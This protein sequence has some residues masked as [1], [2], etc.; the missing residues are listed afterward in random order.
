LAENATPYDLFRNLRLTCPNNFQ[1]NTKAIPDLLWQSVNVF[2]LLPNFVG[3][4][5]VGPCE[6]LP[7]F[8]DAESV[9][10]FIYVAVT[11]PNPIDMPVNYQKLKTIRDKAIEK[12]T[13]PNAASDVINNPVLDVGIYLLGDK[14]DS[15]PPAD[16]LLDALTKIEDLLPKDL[17]DAYSTYVLYVTTQ[18]KKELTKQAREE[19]RRF[20][21]KE[22][23]P[24]FATFEPL[25]QEA[26]DY[27]RSIVK[28]KP[29]APEFPSVSPEVVWKSL[30]PKLASADIT[31]IDVSKVDVHTIDCTDIYNTAYSYASKA[32]PNAR[33]LVMYNRT[34]SLLADALYSLIVSKSTTAVTPKEKVEAEEKR[35]EEMRRREETKIEAADELL[36]ELYSHLVGSPTTIDIPIDQI[37]DFLSTYLYIL[38]QAGLSPKDYTKLEEMFATFLDLLQEA[39]IPPSQ[40][41]EIL[42]KV[43]VLP[44]EVQKS[45]AKSVLQILSDYAKGTISASQATDTIL[46]LIGKPAPSTTTP[47]PPPPTTP[48]P[49]PKPTPQVKPPSKPAPPTKPPTSYPQWLTELFQYN[50]YIITDHKSQ[51]IR[52]FVNYNVKKAIIFAYDDALVVVPN[53]TVSKTSKVMVFYSPEYTKLFVRG[54]ESFARSYKGYGSFSPYFYGPVVGAES[55][56]GEVVDE[57]NIEFIFNIPVVRIEKFTYSYVEYIKK[58][59]GIEVCLMYINNGSVFGVLDN[60]AIDEEPGTILHMTPNG[61]EIFERRIP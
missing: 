59:P 43:I 20:R 50:I 44:P 14:I 29:N 58:L 26:V 17:R 57:R 13:Y 1:F 54:T 55:S 53:L 18:T 22:A 35:Y 30:S 49:Q 34:A 52:Y 23:S 36:N 48:S 42:N 32:P 12:L 8:T 25:I 7:I 10:R 16:N 41:K 9:V 4:P 56:L 40:Y 2:G 21:M 27:C 51:F 5:T 19:Q 47:P 28:P 39:N 37:P 33:N 3:V 46:S 31:S 6:N 60:C 38:N 15:L 45:V 61:L 11:T 24:E